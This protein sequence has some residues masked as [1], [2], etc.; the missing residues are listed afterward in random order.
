MTTEIFF[1]VYMF[2]LYICI[3]NSTSFCKLLAICCIM[4]AFVRLCGPHLFFIEVILLSLRKTLFLY[5]F[6]HMQ[7]YR[8]NSN[9]LKFLFL[10]QNIRCI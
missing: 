3:I 10:C 6:S 8:N 1:R 2:E 4:L 7:F 9:T 5:L